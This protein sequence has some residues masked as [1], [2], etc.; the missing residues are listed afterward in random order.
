MTNSIRVL[1]SF[2]LLMTFSA[3]VLADCESPLTPIIPDGNVASKDELVSAQKAMKNYQSSLVEFRDCLVGMQEAL[4]P[5]AEDIAV[6]TADIGMKFDS[7]VEAET[8][9]AE[10]FNLAVRAYKA[11]QAPVTE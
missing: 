9:V 5:E 4:D 8:K 11:R 10:E 3:H 1:L 6:K 7:S 2:L